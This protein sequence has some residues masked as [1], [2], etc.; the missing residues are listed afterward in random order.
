MNP[1]PSAPCW[2]A[3]TLAALLE[4]RDLAAMHMCEL[5]HGILERRVR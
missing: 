2:F 1:S 5:M 4:R 3:T